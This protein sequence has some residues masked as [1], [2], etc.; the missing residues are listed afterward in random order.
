[1]SMSSSR[2]L[3]MPGGSVGID[4]VAWPTERT[5]VSARGSVAMRHLGQ[6]GEIEQEA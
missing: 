5:F 3:E 1:M 2:W 6:E 4:R